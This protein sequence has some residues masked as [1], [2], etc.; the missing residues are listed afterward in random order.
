MTAP[1]A[2][3]ICDD[4]LR[5]AERLRAEALELALALAAGPPTNLWRT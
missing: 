2:T 5:E 1:T 3:G 4:L